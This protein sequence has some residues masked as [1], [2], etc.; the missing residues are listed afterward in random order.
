MLVLRGS[1]ASREEIYCGEDIGFTIFERNFV[2][3][4]NAIRSAVEFIKNEDLI[5]IE[6][7]ECMEAT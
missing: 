5:D 3:R 1:L 6:K 7:W 4:E 2:P